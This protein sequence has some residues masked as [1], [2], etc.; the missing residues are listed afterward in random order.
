MLRV[1]FD[2]DE[3]SGGASKRL[4]ERYG[5][6]QDEVKK[7]LYGANAPTPTASDVLSNDSGG[8]PMP[9]TEKNNRW[10]PVSILGA[11]LGVIGVLS[12]IVAIIVLQRN[13]P[14]LPWEFHHTMPHDMVQS[15]PPEAVMPAP[16]APKTMDSCCMKPNETSTSQSNTEA[17]VNDEAEAPKPVTKKTHHSM[18]HQTPKGFATSNSME[19]EEH[20]AELRA[21]GNSKAQIRSSTKNGVTTYSVR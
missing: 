5:I 1:L 18:H 6:P 12:L 4:S 13:G 10:N 8:T 2:A 21:E 16:E 3:R 9:I 14:E 19:A 15:M 17:P 20:L 7:L 11:L